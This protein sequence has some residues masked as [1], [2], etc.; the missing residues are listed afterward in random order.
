MFAT[1]K[2]LAIFIL[3]T[4]FSC[5]GYIFTLSQVE[6]VYRFGLEIDLY[7]VVVHIWVIAWAM[8]FLIGMKWVIS[9][10]VPFYW[11]VI[12]T[13]VAVT[14]VLGLFVTV[15]V[16]IFGLPFVSPAMALSLYILQQ[17]KIRNKS[18]QETAKESPF[19]N[20]SST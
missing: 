18:N 7:S 20:Y 1:I 13:A 9:N 17:S 6:F 14:G 11:C 3:A 2:R 19:E 12:G 8:Y 10:Y 4:A 15:V 5:T 16:G